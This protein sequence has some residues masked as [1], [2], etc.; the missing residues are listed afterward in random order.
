[1]KEAAIE[2][3]YTG[4]YHIAD[5]RPNLFRNSIPLSCLALVGAAVFF[6]S[7]LH[8]FIANVC[9]LTQYNCVLDG[10]AKNGNGKTLPEF[11]GKRYSSIFHAM[12]GMLHGIQKD[13]YHGEKLRVQLMEWANEGW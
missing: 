2:F 3:F 7:C 10:F 12:L 11:S 6:T 1:M 9:V 5:K 8:F 4:S 13:P